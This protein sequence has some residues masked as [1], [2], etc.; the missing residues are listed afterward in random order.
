MNWENWGVAI[1]CR[2]YARGE[3]GGRR[4]HKS[5]GLGQSDVANA[6]RPRGAGRMRGAE[7][8]D[9]LRAFNSGHHGGM[10]TVH[11]DG[12]NRVPSRLIS[13]GLLAGVSPQALAMLAA[14]AFDAVVHLE[15]VNGQ[16]RITQIG[17]LRV[18][19]GELA[20]TPLAVWN[21]C[22]PPRYAA[23]W[24]HF[25]ERWGIVPGPSGGG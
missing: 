18:A 25:I 9:L 14:G 10:T 2:W 11:A 17:E 22:H 6:P 3:C 5:D 24:G 16:R 19:H 7:I 8:V 23:E 15:R 13:L 20:G 4:S 21:G 12:V 1:M